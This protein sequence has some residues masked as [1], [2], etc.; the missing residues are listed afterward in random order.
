MV[1]ESLVIPSEMEKTPRDMFYVGFLYASLGLFLAHWIFGSYSSLASVFITA[2]PMVVIM[3]KVLKLEERKDVEFSIY[4]KYGRPLKR[5]FLIKEHGR[6]V[7]LFIFMFIGMVISYTLWSTILPEDVINRLFESQIET[8]KAINVKAVGNAIDPDNALTSILYNNF[9]VLMF[10][11][12]FSFLYG[13]GAIFI[14]TWNASVIGV[15]VGNI[16]RRSIIEC[17]GMSQ[18]MFIYNYLGT[19]SISFSYAIHGIPEIAAYFIGALGGGIISIAVTNHDIKSDRFKGIIIDSADLI[20]LSCI[21]LFI[22]GLIEVYV[23]PNLI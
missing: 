22:A 20:I 7:S 16:I 18:S 15:A 6:A 9:K 19:F 4:E 8:I 3:Y 14:L 23:T 5:S 1:L 17:S 12:L 13:S 2:M 10:C 11:I 21:L